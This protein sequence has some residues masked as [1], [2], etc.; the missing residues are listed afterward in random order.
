MDW[1]F[2]YL[3]FTFPFQDLSAWRGEF[4]F[5]KTRFTFPLFPDFERKMGREMHIWENKS[6][7]VMLMTVKREGEWDF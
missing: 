1:I 4:V 5:L 6:L 2:S 7:S 3:Q